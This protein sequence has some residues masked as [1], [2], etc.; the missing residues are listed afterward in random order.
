VLLFSGERSIPSKSGNWYDYEVE[1]IH[2]KGKVIQIVIQYL[3]KSGTT[4]KPLIGSKPRI[5]LMGG[6][7]SPN[8]FS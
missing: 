4:H 8:N 6:T 7:A 5:D 2:D 3:G 1:T